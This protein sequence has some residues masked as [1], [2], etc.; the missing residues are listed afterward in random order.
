MSFDAHGNL[1]GALPMSGPHYRPID[2]HPGFYRHG[3]LVAFRYRLR[4][5]RRRWASAPNLRAAKRLRQEM[6]TDASRGRIGAPAERFDR[7]A[8]AW[9]ETYPGRTA[10]G[11]RE[12]TRASYRRQLDRYGIPY[13]GARKLDDLAPA[14]IRAFAQHVAREVERKT[15]RAAARDTVRLALAP[16]KAL[17]ATAWE[18]GLIPA[19]P[20]A[21]VRLLVAQRPPETE[22]RAKAWSPAQFAALVGELPAEWRLFAAFLAETG[23]R[24]GEAAELRW[25]DLDL[26]ARTLRV[27]RSYFRGH[28][29]P[30]KSAH[31]RRRL[32]LSDG[33]ARGLW[34]LRKVTRAGERGLVF[35]AEGGTWLNAGNLADRVFRPAAKAAGVP[36]LGFHG[37]RHTCGTI[38]FRDGANAKQVQAWLGHHSPAFTLETY[39]HLLPEDLPEPPSIGVSALA[40]LR[41]ICDP[42]A[43]RTPRNAPN[44]ETAESAG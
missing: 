14:D 27:E 33:L 34:D 39:V 18:D 43:T 17:L 16:V 7:Y 2:G 15:G 6:Q 3:E 40:D 13:F 26:G 41:P 36:W 25:S 44:A 4:S 37:F 12:T 38:L 31:G 11:F 8:R 23:L 1:S 42:N 29:T 10:R 19:N 24:F 21:G 28:V 30:P 5:G 35:A 9:I 20:S 32:R 22:E